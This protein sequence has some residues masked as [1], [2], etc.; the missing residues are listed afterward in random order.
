LVAFVAVVGL[1]DLIFLARSLSE[2]VRPGLFARPPA[3]L[4]REQIL[5][6]VRFLV[7]IQ[8]L[9]LTFTLL[10]GYWVLLKWRQ[11]SA[12]PFVAFLALSLLPVASIAIILFIYMLRM[13]IGVRV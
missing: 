6:D 7:G 11:G 9:A 3:R 8:N 12:R 13:I 1:F 5:D 4:H 10:G 2:P